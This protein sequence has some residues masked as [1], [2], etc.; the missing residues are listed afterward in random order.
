MMN[1]KETRSSDC[2]VRSAVQFL[3]IVNNSGAEIRRHLYTTYRENN[4]IHF[5]NVQQ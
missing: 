4:V 2:E 1:W 3:T 5:R